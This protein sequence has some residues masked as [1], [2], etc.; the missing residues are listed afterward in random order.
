MDAVTD[1]KVVS[2]AYVL[3]VEGEEVARTEQD[4]PMDYLHGAQNILPGLEKALAGKQLGDKFAVTLTPEEAYGEYDEENIEEIDREDIPGA[5]E[6]E[7]GMVVEVEDDDGYYVAHVMEIGKGTIVLDFNPPLAGKTLTYEVE[8]V[9]VRDADE[10]ELAHGHAHGV[11]TDE[12]E[13]DFD[14]DDFDEDEYDDDE[15]EFDDEI[16]EIDDDDTLN[17]RPRA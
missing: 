15:E 12:D 4:D 6:L 8:I 5:D 2:L 17:G 10:E 16:E 1:G 13:D 9:G 14:E 7:V 11:W 3:T